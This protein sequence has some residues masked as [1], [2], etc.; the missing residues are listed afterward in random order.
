MLIIFS[1][2][3]SIVG[4]AHLIATLLRY[5]VPIDSKNSLGETALH[6]AAYSGKLLITEQL[7]DKGANIDAVNNDNETPLF[8]AARCKMY[9]F[10]S[11]YFILT[12]PSY[13]SSSS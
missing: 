8:Y 6:L 2:L 11:Y 7:I 9:H 13:Y 5:G 1:R 12:H 4:H 10:S 3:C